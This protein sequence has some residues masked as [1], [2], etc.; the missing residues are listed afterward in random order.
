MAKSNPIPK[1]AVNILVEYK[2]GLLTLEQA[3]D[4]FSY[5]TGLT[6]DIAQTFIKGMSRQNIVDLEAWRKQQEKNDG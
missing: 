1:A 5:V 3:V 2:R 4:R 6:K